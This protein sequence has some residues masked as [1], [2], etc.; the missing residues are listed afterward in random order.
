[1]SWNNNKRHPLDRSQHCELAKKITMFR[2]IGDIYPVNDDTDLDN[3]TFFADRPDPTEAELKQKWGQ[4]AKRGE[5]WSAAV[6][7]E[8]K[9]KELRERAENMNMSDMADSL[10]DV[11]AGRLDLT[12]L[13]EALDALVEE[14][15]DELQ[16]FT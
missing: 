4:M 16:I 3:A 10:R 7:A 14:D 11:D 8:R 2:K 1:M 6:D 5:L 12:S 13:K 9:R 15:E